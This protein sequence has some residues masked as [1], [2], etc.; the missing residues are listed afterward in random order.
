MAFWEWFGGLAFMVNGNMAVGVKAYPG[1]LGQ[2]GG[3]KPWA[4]NAD[5]ATALGSVLTTAPGHRYTATSLI[6]SDRISSRRAT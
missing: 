3:S 6:T 5:S 1:S 2:M 4:A